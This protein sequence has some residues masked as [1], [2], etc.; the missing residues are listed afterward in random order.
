MKHTITIIT[1]IALLSTALPVHAQSDYDREIQQ[2]KEKRDR[3]I[4]LAAGPIN[5]DYANSLQQLLKR[6][7][8]ASKLDVA[9]E[10]RKELESLSVGTSVLK[11][12]ALLGR[13]KTDNKDNAY[14][15][16]IDPDGTTT[17][18]GGTLSGTWAVEGDYLIIHWGN[19]VIMRFL[20]SEKGDTIHFQ[21]KE[22]RGA[23]V[24]HSASRL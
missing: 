23:W 3:A 24:T 4:A 22:P 9:V 19:S 12:T 18:V 13:W 10:I 5:R 2:L 14:P 1:Y 11:P 7:M 16:S 8:Q 15:I 17:F 6:A 20:T 21:Q